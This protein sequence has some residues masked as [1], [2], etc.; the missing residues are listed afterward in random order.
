MNIN[1]FF[2][3]AIGEKVI[4]NDAMSPKKIKVT[5]SFL[6]A[7]DETL[8]LA[9]A[10]SITLSNK[11]ENGMVRPEFISSV[12]L[13]DGTGTDKPVIDLVQQGGGMYG[14]AL[15]GYTYIMEKAGIRF[16]SHGGT[17]A[18]GINASLLA[19]IPPSIYA[20]DSI[21]ARQSFSTKSELLA[22]IITNTDFT[23]FLDAGGVIGRLQ[24]FLLKKYKSKWLLRGF[25]LAALLFLI[26]CFGAFSAIF[27]I[28]NGLTGTELRTF[29]FIIGTFS[30]IALLL[31]IYILLVKLFRKDFGI[32]SGA[33]FYQWSDKLFGILGVHDTKALLDRIN[34]NKLSVARPDDRARLVMIASNLTNHRIAKFPERASDYWSAPQHV[35]PAAY[36]R[37]TMSLPFIFRT[38][39]PDMTHYHMASNDAIVSKRVRFVDGGMLSNFPIREFHKNDGQPPRFPT[40]GVLL[41]D[42]GLRKGQTKNERIR[43]I[44]S[45]KLQE[46]KFSDYIKSYFKTF[47]NFYDYDFVFGSN[48]IARRV[49]TVDTQDFNWLDFWMDK[50]TKMKLFIKGAEA[51]IEQLEKF[52]WRE[53]RQERAK[54]EGLI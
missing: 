53:Y 5:A 52:D 44:D 19:A 10:E 7:A 28:S 54:V 39:I 13:D 30:F 51:A 22:H 45:S 4:A 33:R 26:A 37:A 11:F 14:I 32:N 24:Q 20:S 36:L 43:A 2:Q 50:D 8:E 3:A 48:E 21:F 25:L 49:V 6:A 15:V 34:A 29:D 23:R 9:L 41:S 16:H 35:K 46:E 40:F 1:S 31:L 38:F 17:S 27:S 12:L 18:G 47:R 42:I